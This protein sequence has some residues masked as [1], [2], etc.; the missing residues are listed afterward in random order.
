MTKRALLL[1]VVLGLAVAGLTYFNDHVVRQ[2]MLIGNHLPPSVFGVVLLVLLGVNP[3][4]RAVSERA[5]FSAAE[6]AVILALALVVCGY[7]GSNLMRFFNQLMVLPSHQRNVQ[8]NWQATNVFSYVPGGSDL[9]AE[10]YVTDWPALV[11]GLDVA[12]RPD[13]PAP[14]KRLWDQ[15]DRQTQVVIRQSAGT[16]PSPR[17]RQR[18]VNGINEV[19]G[20]DQ[21]WDAEAFADVA[22]PAEA[23]RLLAEWDK[24]GLARHEREQLNRA[25]ISAVFEGLI[26]SPPRGEGVLLLGGRSD[27]RITEAW[28]MGRSGS[29]TM[30]VADVPWRAWWPT[31]RLWLGLVLLMSLATLCLQ[32]IVHRQWAEHEM[33]SY[34]IV[35][36]V[37]EVTAWRRGAWLPEVAGA[38]L[39]WIG[40][41]LVAGL[42]LVNGLHAWFPD[43]PE[44]NRRLDFTALRALFPL[45]STVPSNDKLFAP[46]IFPAVIGFAYFINARVSASV[47][48]SLVFWVLLGV[49]L[50]TFGVPLTNS[51]LGVGSNGNAIRFGAYLAMT[52][53]ILYLGR[54][55]YLRVAAGAVGLPRGRSAPRYAVW[56]FRGLVAACGLSVWLLARYAGLDPMLGVLLVAMMLMMMLVLARINCETGM[57]YAQPDW[58][59]GAIL[60]GFLGVQG[61]G[62]EGLVVMTLASLVLAADP[63]EGLSPYLANALRLGDRVGRTGPGRVAWPIIL[64]LVLGLAVAFTATVT[65]QYN[66]GKGSNGWAIGQPRSAF[67]HL[68]AAI[69]DLSARGELVESTRVEGLDHLRMARP[70]G[71]LM[72]Y[73]G[74]GLLAVLLCAWGRLRFTWWPIHPVLFVVLGTYPGTYFA[75]SFLLAALVKT[76]VV[77]L[78]G[79]Q[80]YH[81]VR[82]LMVGLIAGEILMIIAW[83]IV[84]MTAFLITGH[85]PQSYYIWPM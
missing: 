72:I 53:M 82:P 43:V 83:A 50:M 6:L 81:R 1:G 78:G 24:R 19:L 13:A 64:M 20:R 9:L 74:G 70:H 48:L 67:N 57:F 5:P 17:H 10:G 29:R 11:R 45:A 42:H 3:L 31:L 66:Y 79:E 63:R 23:Q 4:L 84:G 38:R 85:A 35:R 60:A 30:G 71:A 39:F 52:G 21:W 58:M 15:L 34:P 65:L 33:L 22:R 27:E 80:A 51:K 25:L 32:L 69:T 37:E 77:R 47:G 28:V 61:L 55:Y 16:D 40:L 26:R 41:A 46:W 59:P 44:I 49:V 7:P 68:S 76:A 14:V 18:I 12:D 62:A 73:V 36:F 75:F 8:A 56:A 2:T 54:S